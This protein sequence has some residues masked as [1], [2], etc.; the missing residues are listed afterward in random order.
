VGD[1]LTL[2]VTR[3]AA[4]VPGMVFPPLP[5][6]AIDGLGVYHGSP[7]VNDR[8]NRGSLIGKRTDSVT[9][10][11]EREGRYDLPELRFQWWDPDQE[12]L[13]DKVIPAVE[14]AVA[15]NPAFPAE[16]SAT[17]DRSG[18]ALNWKVAGVVI[19]MLL[20][21]YPAMLLARKLMTLT[22]EWQQQRK[23]GESWAFQQVLKTC[24]SGQPAAAYNAI[25][26]WLGRC[27]N[28]PTGLTLTGLATETGD[29]ALLR[30]STILQEKV[31]TGST[32]KWSG[33]EL[34]QLL[35]KCRKHAQKQVKTVN[36]LHPLNPQQFK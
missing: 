18:P 26:V 32:G 30:E 10:I 29:G 23:A 5:A 20:L 28:S 3:S 19:V 25:T 13:S 35:V 11:C 7:A 6:F 4:D 8:I 27:S 12:I 34:A 31:A 24:A 21:G 17:R 15:F 14:L 36:V 1:A 16:E 9:F 22:R 2:E 33:R